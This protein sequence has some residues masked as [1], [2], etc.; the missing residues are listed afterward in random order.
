P[1][2]ITARLSV[3]TPPT[4]P[5]VVTIR[6]RATIGGG[7]LVWEQIGLAVAPADANVTTIAMASGN[8]P[9]QVGCYDRATITWEMEG[10]DGRT[11][12]LGQTTHLLYTL[13][14]VPATPVIGAIGAMPTPPPYWTLLEFSCR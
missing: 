4:D 9:D 10:P 7:A 3:T 8:L 12:D 2:T 1:V 5:E 14:D 6:G 11:T 13:L